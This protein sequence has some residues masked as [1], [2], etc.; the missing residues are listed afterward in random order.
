MA[1]GMRSADKGRKVDRVRND[2]VGCR[3]MVPTRKFDLRRIKRVVNP[4]LLKQFVLDLLG[5]YAE[6]IGGCG[7]PC[8][9][10]H[11]VDGL[12]FG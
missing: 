4:G 12:R 7:V 6:S 3:V 1:G 5:L 9:R 10:R 11:A 8:K 2:I